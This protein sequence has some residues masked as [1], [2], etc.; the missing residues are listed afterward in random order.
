MAFVKTRPDLLKP[1][2]QIIGGPGYFPP[3]VK[4]SGF[5]AATVLVSVQSR[6]HLTLRSPDPTQ[7]PAIYANYFSAEEDLQALVEGV[8][9]VRRLA[10]TKAYAPFYEREEV[11]GPEIQSVK[12][13]IEFLR[14]NVQT[15]FHPVGTCK[16]GN[17][18]MAVVDQHS[19]V[20]K[21]DNLR[22]VDAS[23]MPTISSG[24]TNAPTIM[25]AEKI[26]E[27]LRKARAEPERHPARRHSR[28]D[29]SVARAAS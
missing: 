25:I 24:N 18:A 26:A 4:G 22:I 20:H 11:P 8:N 7:L 13:L 9:I 16:M 14:S 27:G 10:R 28:T 6:G 5:S 17:D 12:Q 23:I 21:I 2:V 1:D 3:T 15:M 19:R 29:L